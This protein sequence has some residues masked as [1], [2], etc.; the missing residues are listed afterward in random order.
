[1]I[2]WMVVY[3]LRVGAFPV[4]LMVDVGLEHLPLLFMFDIRLQV[5]GCIMYEVRNMVGF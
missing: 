5:A 1:M 2:T 3:S 4:V